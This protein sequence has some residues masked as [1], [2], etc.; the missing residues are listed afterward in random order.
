MIGDDQSRHVYGKKDEW[1]TPQDLFDRLNAKYHFT[2]DAAASNS[3]HKCPEYYTKDQDG[4]VQDWGNDTVYVNPPYGRVI[5]D[6]VHKAYETHQQ[7][8]NTIVMLLPART[9]TC[10]FHDYI[11][12][13]ADI[14]FIKGRL[15]FS[16]SKCNSPFPNMIVIFQG[17]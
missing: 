3:N 6:W 10:W 12:G 16:G 7:Y 1:E 14:K 9:D 2:L 8:G 17:R 13:Q 5:A 4:L 11:Y 15:R